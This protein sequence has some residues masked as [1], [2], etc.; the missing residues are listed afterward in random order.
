MPSQ[1]FVRLGPTSAPKSKELSVAPVGFQPNP[2]DLVCAQVPH[3]FD[4]GSQVLLWLGSDNNKGQATGWTQ[5]IRAFATCGAKNLQPGSKLFEVQLEKVFILPRTIEKAELLQH[6]PETYAVELADASVIGLNNYAS[7]VVQILT[8]R[9]FAALAAMIADILPEVEPAITTLVPD[10][11]DIKIVP[12]PPG[13]ETEGVVEVEPEPLKA[14]ID[15]DD[16]VYLEVKNLLDDGVGGVLLVGPPGTGK[17][18][19]ARQIAIK[20]AA[21]KKSRIKEIQFHPSYQYEDFV[22]G[23]VPDSDKGFRLTDKH[24]LQMITIAQASAEPAVLIID[25]FSRTDPARVMG[26]TLTYM[27]GS[28]RGVE[29]S[30]PSGRSTLIP[31]NLTFIATMNPEDRSVDEIDAAMERRW[32]KVELHPDSE[33]MKRLVIKA[34]MPEPYIEPV[35]SFFLAIQQYMPIGHAF[36]RTVKDVASLQRLWDTQLR[37]LVKKRFRFDQ[38]TAAEVTALWETCSKACANKS[39]PAP[40]SPEPVAE[41]PAP[42]P[43][44]AGA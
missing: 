20:I 40:P 38:E 34:G 24:L 42:E 13:D 22:E 18:Y 27:E 23:Y 26:E 35:L 41:P 7:Q 15:D 8:Q 14:E 44:A 37:Y 9:E 32:A 43:A 31:K 17:T 5:G 33:A 11:A 28:L 6:S 19:Y 16:E 30:L 39:P 4:V 25:E 10:S 2:I 1:A 21:G 12:R 36:F 3:D 29:F